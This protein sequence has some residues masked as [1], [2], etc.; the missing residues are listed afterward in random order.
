MADNTGFRN[1]PNHYSGLYNTTSNLFNSIGD[2]VSGLASYIGEKAPILWDIGTKPYPED[3]PIFGSGKD[4][5]GYTPVPSSMEPFSYTPIEDNT[6]SGGYSNFDPN[7]DEPELS[8]LD[9]LTQQYGDLLD[10][11]ASDFKRSR[12]K[13]G[14][15]KQLTAPKVANPEKPSKSLGLGG[16]LNV[17]DKVHR[18]KGVRDDS[19][20][21]NTLAR[22]NELDNQYKRDLQSNAL[23][24]ARLMMQADRFNADAAND[25]AYRVASR[26]D[27]SMKQASR[28]KQSKLD[29]LL[30]S[31]ELIKDK[32]NKAFEKEYKRKLMDIK[33]RELDIK[34]QKIKARMAG[35]SELAKS[36]VFNN[37]FSK[38]YKQLAQENPPKEYMNP[39]TWFSGDVSDVAKQV[40]DLS[41]QEYN[42]L[43]NTSAGQGTPVGSGEKIGS[44][45]LNQLNNM[46]K[47][48]IVNL[49]RMNQG[50]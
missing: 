25:L 30:T 41:I 9:T 29:N 35:A 34:E 2:D 33:D 36:S 23:N 42:R 4:S 21:Y 11:D 43:N 47:D 40:M 18:G 32:E 46:T 49:S 44:I 28:E 3:N 5:Y 38:I 24:N 19:M 8:L 14:K 13:I 27:D 6:Q 26:E 45:D 22:N 17:F 39:K 15:L 37:I 50:L 10:T 12:S 7:G 1:M 48:D 20:L 16:L 31:I